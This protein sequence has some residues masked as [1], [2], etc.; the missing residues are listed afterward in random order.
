MQ[1]NF[2]RNFRRCCKSQR[3]GGGTARARA[4]PTER[5]E[6]TGLAYA[7]VGFSGAVYAYAVNTDSQKCT[8]I[9]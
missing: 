2:K 5:D 3:S 9:L 8:C 6:Q 7:Y 1:E 4:S